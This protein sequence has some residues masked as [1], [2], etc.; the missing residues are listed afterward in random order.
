MLGQALVSYNVKSEF[1]ALHP[2]LNNVMIN[3]IALRELKLKRYCPF[4]EN[5]SFL[6]HTSVDSKAV[7]K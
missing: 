7:T 6:A 3:S 2:Q 1:L 5:K 4:L